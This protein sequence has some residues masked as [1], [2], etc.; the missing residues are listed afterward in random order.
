MAKLFVVAPTTS[1]TQFAGIAHPH[2]IR[3]IHGPAIFS[4]RQLPPAVHLA[5][6]VDIRMLYNPFDT[7]TEQLIEPYANLFIGQHLDIKYE[8]K[9]YEPLRNVLI[10]HVSE[11]EMR[12]YAQAT[13]IAVIVIDQQMDDLVISDIISP[14]RDLIY[15]AKYQDYLFEDESSS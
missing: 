7:F 8:F 4:F 2:A 14:P 12:N 9:P 1:H 10:G 3:G 13:Q 11:D 6:A 15:T 5:Q